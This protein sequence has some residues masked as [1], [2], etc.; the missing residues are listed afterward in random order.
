MSLIKLKKSGSKIQPMCDVS[1]LKKVGTNDYLVV[2][3][4]GPET[5]EMLKSGLWSE[6][7]KKTVIF[8]GIGI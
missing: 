8:R 7:D 5:L 4:E 2:F 3:S 1:L 6:K